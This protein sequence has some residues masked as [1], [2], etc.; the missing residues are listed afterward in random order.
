[1][2]VKQTVII[3]TLMQNVST[4]MDLSSVSVNQV[5]MEMGLPNVS[6]SRIYVYIY[7]Y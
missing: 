1:M 4:I 6:V 5:M 2:S 3:V 7:I